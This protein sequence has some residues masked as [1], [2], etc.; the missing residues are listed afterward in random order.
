[1]FVRPWCGL[2]SLHI[3]FALDLTMDAML[4]RHMFVAL[5]VEETTADDEILIDDHHCGTCGSETGRPE[6][7]VGMEVGL[8]SGYNKTDNVEPGLLRNDG[9]DK[10]KTELFNREVCEMGAK[11]FPELCFAAVKYSAGNS[12]LIIMQ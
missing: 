11:C 6:V 9:V 2:K 10:V 4:S 12:M 8:E 1:M 7:I 3:W 5:Q